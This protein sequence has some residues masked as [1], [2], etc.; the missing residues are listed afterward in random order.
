[1]TALDDLVSVMHRLRAEC[2]WDA[3]QTHE[4]LVPYLLEESAELVDAIETGDRDG[5]REELGDVLYQVLFHADIA[6]GAEG[7]DIQDVAALTAE[8]MK[9]RHPHVFG[10]SVAATPDEIRA[11]WLEV[12]AAEKASRTSVLDGIP[13]GM[14]ALA[15]AGKLLGRAEQV[16]ALD[17]GGVPSLPFDDEDELGALL[18]ALVRAGRARGFDADRALR[19]TLRGLEDEIRSTEQPPA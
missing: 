1:M 11:Q 8:K 9:R 5:I 19:A 17:A 14:S 16:G 2:A 13:R 18:L 6:S 10:D 3:E 7:F 15:L 12:K 4:T